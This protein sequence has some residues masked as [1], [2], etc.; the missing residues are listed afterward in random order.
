MPSL[1][2]EAARLKAPTTEP[3]SLQALASRFGCPPSLAALSRLPSR[4]AISDRP[5]EAGDVKGSYTLTLNCDGKWDLSGRVHDD[6]KLFGDA[7]KFKLQVLVDGQPALREI[8]E[9]GGLS[10]G[11]TNNF[12]PEFGEDDRLVKGWFA[13]SQG[14]ASARWSLQLSLGTGAIVAIATGGASIPFMFITGPPPSSC[15]PSQVSGCSPEPPP[16]GGF[17]A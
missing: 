1:R 11:E 8:V 12:G 15:S 14:R 6:G 17:G 5:I 4:V 13:A 10:A 9:S 3:L 7:Y 2:D 16:G